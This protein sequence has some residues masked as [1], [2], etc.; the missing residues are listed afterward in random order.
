MLVCPH[1]PCCLF[2][3]LIIDLSTHPLACLLG[4]NKALITPCLVCVSLCLG[5]CWWTAW[6][7]QPPTLR[8]GLYPTQTRRDDASGLRLTPPAFLPAPPALCCVGFLFVLLTHFYFKLGFPFLN[9]ISLYTDRLGLTPTCDPATVFCAMKPYSH[10]LPGRDIALIQ[11][12][13]HHQTLGATKEKHA[14]L[15]HSPSNPHLQSPATGGP[16]DYWRVSGKRMRCGSPPPLFPS[17]SPISL[18]SPSPSFSG[19]P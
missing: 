16:G 13:D 4:A 19:S 1:V 11:N 6:P 10:P 14:S 18:G 12:P 17:C 2:Q 15:S 3:H 9:A 5:S 8:P 7:C